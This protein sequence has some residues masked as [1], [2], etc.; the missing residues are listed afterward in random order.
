MPPCPLCGR[1]IVPG[2]SA[3]EHHLV[4][5]SEGG[6]D[7]TLV[8]RVCHRKIHATFSEKELARG[9]AS[10]EALRGHP[11][12]ASFVQWVRK[13]P[14]EFNDGSARPRRRR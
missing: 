12:I 7:K 13:K 1:P 5:K 4:P 14:P 10:W 2:P 9:Y 6:R 8:H 11:E 3:D